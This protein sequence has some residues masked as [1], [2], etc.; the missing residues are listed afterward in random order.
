MGGNGVTGVVRVAG[1]IAIAG[2]IVSGCTSHSSNQG[3]TTSQTY[4]QPFDVCSLPDSVL[5]QAGL[6]P[7]TKNAASPANHSIACQWHNSDVHVL[8]NANTSLTLQ[9]L[10]AEP[11]NTSFSDITVAGRQGQQFNGT[12]DPITKTCSLAFPVSNAGVV[13]FLA[14][15]SPITDSPRTACELVQGVAAVLLPAL[16]A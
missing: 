16:H 10:R 13:V 6:D 3:T 9:D 11:G 12:P 2:L 7:A 8:I 14:E 1:V 4:A 5:R 15:K